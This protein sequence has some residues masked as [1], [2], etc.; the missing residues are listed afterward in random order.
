[1]LEVAR[2]R[3][4]KF[5]FEQ[6]DALHMKYSD[7]SFDLV[8]VSFGVRNFENLEAGL[9]EICRVLKPG[10]TIAVLEFG[11]PDGLVF[12][13][14]YNFYS[15]YLMPRIGGFLTGNMEA[16]SYLPATAARFPCGAAFGEI[17]ERCGFRDVR[18]HRY[19]FGI[20]FGYWAGK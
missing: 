20:A 10:G 15:K 16:Y 6:C 8:T 2:K 11:Q 7:A 18:R 19:T 4:P 13:P 3:F 14:V 9:Q 17:L 5:T 1:M 12:A